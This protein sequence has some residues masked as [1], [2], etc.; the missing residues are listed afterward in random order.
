MEFKVRNI[1]TMLYG[2]WKEGIIVIFVLRLPSS[3]SGRMGYKDSEW[4]FKPA[5]VVIQQVCG[6]YKTDN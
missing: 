3:F 6:A 4:C 1:S 2:N 5:S